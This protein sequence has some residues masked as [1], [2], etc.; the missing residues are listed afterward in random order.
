[1]PDQMTLGDVQHAVWD[2]STSIFVSRDVLP[3][4]AASTVLSG[5]TMTIA[6]DDFIRIAFSDNQL[7]LQYATRAHASDPA[8][9]SDA[10]QL[11]NI[12]TRGGD[13]SNLSIAVGSGGK[14]G[15]SYFFNLPGLDA[16][17]IY[18]EEMPSGWV[19]DT[20]DPGPITFGQ[21][22]GSSG[23]SVLPPE[24]ANSLVIDANGVPHI[25]FFGGGPGGPGIRYS[26]WTAAGRF[27]WA[28]AGYGELIDKDGQ[29]SSAKILLDKSNVLH[30]AYQASQGPAATTTELRFA[31]RTVSGWSMETVDPSINSGWAISAAIHPTTGEPH[32]AYGF[33]SMGMG[34][35]E[36]KHTWALDLIRIPFPHKRPPI[37][38]VTRPD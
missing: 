38:I 21:I 15:M 11:T 24:G 7:G 23:I 30:V 4:N 19:R 5:I 6:K 22:T 32:I 36:L 26:T 29:P 14:T 27:S 31:T 9:D 16:Q 12:E 18:A 28:I 20:A 1:M 17:L 10:F 8:R 35:F 33:E 13:F 34:T 37:N 2:S 25:A 3:A